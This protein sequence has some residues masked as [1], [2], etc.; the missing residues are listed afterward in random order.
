[1]D[2][3]LPP[4]AQGNDF[5]LLLPRHFREDVVRFLEQDMPSFDVGAFV[6]GTK[7]VKAHLLAKTP[8]ILAGMPFFNAVFEELGCEVRWF[9]TEGCR[10]DLSPVAEAAAQGGPP[11]EGDFDAT[12]SHFIGK[13]KIA[14]VTGPVCRLLQGERTALNIISR[15][16][17]IATQT[18]RLVAIK[19]EHG[20]HGEIAATRK[21]TP[22]FRLFEKY[23]VVVGGGVPHR[24]TLSDM[25]MLK[26]NHCWACGGDIQA[27]VRKARSACGFSNKIEVEC[28]SL[29]EAVEAA[30]AGAEVVML[31]NFPAPEA[32]TAA[33]KLKEQFPHGLTVEISGG[34]NEE[35]AAEYFSEHVDVL[36]FGSLTHGYDV[37]DFSLKVM[38]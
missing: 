15:C 18:N 21:V 12:T 19:Q 38:G 29:A 3:F 28:Q 31:D 7:P 2:N 20:W 14:E 37:L 36:S 22:G 23:A 11:P 30:T 10:L 24:M 16:S 13:M 25:T 27:M 1:M 4:G 26:D 17:G 32:K 33:A 8:G 5:A 6:V 9:V 34:L 35:T